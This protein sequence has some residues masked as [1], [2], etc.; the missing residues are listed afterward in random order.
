[1]MFICK[2]SLFSVPT[3]AWCVY[4]DTIVGLN[5]KTIFTTDIFGYFI[6]RKQ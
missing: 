1:M 3:A 4:L 5:F 2:K 6:M